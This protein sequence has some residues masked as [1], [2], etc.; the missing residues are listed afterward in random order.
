MIKSIKIRN[1]KSLE[2]V[3]LSL[4]RFNLFVGTNSSGKSNFLD[5]LRLLQGI[6]NGFTISE[7][8][9]GKPRTATTEVWEGIR[10]GSEFASFRLESDVPD[11]ERLV[12]LE[13]RVEVR[14]ADFKYFD[15]HIAFYPRR[16]KIVT[17]WLS[18]QGRYLFDSTKYDNSDLSSPTLAVEYSKGTPGTKGNPGRPPRLWFERSRPVLHQFAEHSVC[19]AAD[20]KALAGC[21][22]A[23]SDVQRLDPSPEVLRMYSTPQTVTRM[24]ERGENFAALVNA[25][26][27][28][29][30]EKNAYLE[31]LKEL[32]PADVDDVVVLPGALKEPLFAVVE[33]NKKFPAQV[34]SDGTLRFAAITAAFFQH[35]M[36]AVLTLEEIEKGIHPSR[37]RLL[38]EL[39]RSQTKRL[40]SQV[41]ATTH[42]PDILNWL[43]EEDLRSTF[44]SVRDGE[45]GC[46]SIRAIGA[47]PELADALKSNA[48]LAELFSEG[49]LESIA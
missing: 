47:L 8:L 14:D 35:A 23:L 4:G 38:V 29:P 16:G 6:G 2:S 32:S 27:S 30:K 43:S 19:K 24:G 46:S 18:L 39:L 40:D 15:Y 45:R 12:E 42:S 17:E 25:I 37:L 49:W 13:V 48:S 9:N 28:V 11:V 33:G 34:L 7:I 3:D 5:A 10:G 26:I 21:I 20:R 44:V 41:I 36:P 1:F 22:L 31:W